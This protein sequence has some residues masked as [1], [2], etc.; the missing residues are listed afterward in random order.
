MNVAHLLTRPATKRPSAHAIIEGSGDDPRSRITFAELADRSARCA[1]FL[2]DAGI[3]V[4][5]HVLVF[6]PMSID[7]YLALIAI[8]R[9]G[10]VAA[11]LDPSA[12]AQHI[13]R[14]CDMIKPKG[15]IA[16]TKA[17]LLRL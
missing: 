4:G 14:C 6:V 11:F 16:V 2:A 3:G 13:N 15:M 5:D 7:L 17:H 10:A 12:G 9:I 8:F 1:R